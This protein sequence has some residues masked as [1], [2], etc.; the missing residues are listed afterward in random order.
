[1]YCRFI[2]QYS[3]EFQEI[4]VEEC[5]KFVTSFQ[6]YQEFIAYQKEVRARQQQLE[7][8]QKVQSRSKESGTLSE[9]TKD[10]VL[11]NS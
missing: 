5:Q 7:R 1:M 9:S 11:R 3:S 6:A 2:L 4:F 8:V 10:Y